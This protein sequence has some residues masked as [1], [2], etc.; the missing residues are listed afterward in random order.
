M[1]NGLSV[2]KI[3][4]DNYRSYLCHSLIPKLLNQT[5]GDDGTL[6]MNLTSQKQ[7]L[8]LLSGVTTTERNR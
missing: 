7:C 1:R 8:A 5:Y 2:Y 6:L 4:L 3:K